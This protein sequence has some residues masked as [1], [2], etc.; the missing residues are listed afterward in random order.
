[1]DIVAFTDSALT[2]VFSATLAF[3]AWQDWTQRRIA[4]GAVLALLAC[5]VVRWI[6]ES[7]NGYELIFNLIIASLI[8][9]P[10]LMRAVLG[11]G[12]V[13]M[14]FALAPLLTTDAY[15]QAFSFGLVILVGACL[16]ADQALRRFPLE[17]CQGCAQVRPNE[18]MNQLR[19]RGIPLGTA[20]SLGWLTTL[21]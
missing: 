14:L 16:L 5:A 10:G 18:L 19:E 8:S 21:L 12:D 4:N 20:V 7:P 1:M 3:I 11:A 15:F 2:I 17:A 13:K 6:T 9:V